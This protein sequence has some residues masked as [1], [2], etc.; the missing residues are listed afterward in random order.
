MFVVG[1]G[2]R[3]AV[4][5]PVDLHCGRAGCAGH[6]GERG[7]KLEQTQHPK[8]DWVRRFMGSSRQN[9]DAVE[10]ADNEFA[11]HGESKTSP[12]FDPLLYIL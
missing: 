5:V 4:V 12:D 10:V 8:W 3:L 1:G 2:R 6:G 9:G 7:G 11:A